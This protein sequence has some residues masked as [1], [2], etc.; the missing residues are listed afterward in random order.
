MVSFDPLSARIDWFEIYRP[1]SLSMV[2]LYADGAAMEC[3]CNGGNIIFGREAIAEYWRGRFQD[4]PAGE[5]TDLQPDR[6]AIVAKYWMPAGVVQATLDFDPN[7]KIERIR[8]GPAVPVGS[9]VK[10]DRYSWDLLCPACGA[11]GTARLSE[12]AFPKPS[13]LHFRVDELSDGFQLRR[14]G[15]SAADT[16]IICVKCG[17]PA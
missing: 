3:N 9:R 2:D 12:E 8:C 10:R 4:Q 7:G 17:V 13:Q 1:A 5:L 15:R 11:A 16:E 6:D 14:Q